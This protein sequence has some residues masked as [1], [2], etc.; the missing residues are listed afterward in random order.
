MKLSIVLVIA[1]FAV[2]ASARTVNTKLNAQ[3]VMD[4]Y[5]GLEQIINDLYS[6]VL[7]VV[8]SICIKNSFY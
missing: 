5:P 1:L 6:N 8:N 7:T 3:T 2:F 4:R